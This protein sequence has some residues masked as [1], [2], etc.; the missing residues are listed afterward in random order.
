MSDLHAHD[1]RIPG[2][3]PEPSRTNVGDRLAQFERRQRQMWR[4][5]YFLLSLLTIAYVA[6]SWD[7]IRSFARRFEFLL[8]AGP[9]LILLVAASIIFV[10]KRNRE[11]AELRGLVRGIEQRDTSPPSD[12]QLNKLF[13]V[14]ER[15]QQGYRDLIDSFDDVLVA[16]TLEGEIRAANRSF[17]DLVGSTFQTI[18]GHSISEFLQDAGGDGPNLIERTL[19]RFLEKRHW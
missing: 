9:I 17:A 13:S 3:S 14:I 16:V 11:I 19:P 6:V 2:G 7:T 18:I 1:A 12:H 4:I 10:W 8:A 5:T 15:S